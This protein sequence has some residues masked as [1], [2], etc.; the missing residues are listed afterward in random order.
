MDL[1]LVETQAN[2]NADFNKSA[3]YTRINPV[4]KIPAFEGANGY[5][6]SEAIAIAVY[7]TLLY[8]LLSIALSMSLPPLPFNDE[9]FYYKL[10][11]PGRT[12]LLIT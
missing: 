1:E 5:T 3:E 12:T 9:Q 11:I 8:Y 6:L 4:G 10:V 7:G 2:A